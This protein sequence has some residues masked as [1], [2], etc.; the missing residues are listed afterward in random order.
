MALGGWAPTAYDLIHRNVLPD[1]VIPGGQAIA[2]Y[3]ETADGVQ[4]IVVLADG[5]WWSL[6]YRQLHPPFAVAS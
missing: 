2:F 4:D 1:A 3:C 6:E 5:R